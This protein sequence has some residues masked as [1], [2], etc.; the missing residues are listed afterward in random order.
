L[1]HYDLLIFQIILSIDPVL[2]NPGHIQHDRPDIKLRPKYLANFGPFLVP[3]LHPLHGFRGF[4][5]PV[6]K[7]E[8]VEVVWVDLQLVLQFRR[9]HNEG[10]RLL[11]HCA[12]VG[13]T[14]DQLLAD[15]TALGG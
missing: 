3:D 6:N 7:P 9:P 14:L 15:V 2:I 5:I 11:A 8:G 4:I 10:E 1:P 13:R 12:H